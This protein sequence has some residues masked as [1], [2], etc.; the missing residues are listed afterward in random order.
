MYVTV[1]IYL[2]KKNDLTHE[3]FTFQIINYLLFLIYL[4]LLNYIR[5]IY[6][7]IYIY[8][9]LQYCNIIIIFL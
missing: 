6:I 7:Y 9:Y 4:K 8:I 3:K 1:H 5:Y 2:F